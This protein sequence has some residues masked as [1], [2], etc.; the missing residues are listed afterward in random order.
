MWK[1]HAFP[2]GCSIRTSR[3][4]ECGYCSKITWTEPRFPA[5]VAERASVFS[6]KAACY[7]PLD[8]GDRA[9]FRGTWLGHGERRHRFVIHGLTSAIHGGRRRFCARHGAGIFLF[10]SQRAARSVAR[11]SVD[12]CQLAGAT[13]STSFGTPNPLPAANRRLPVRHSE[14]W[15]HTN[16][17]RTLLRRRRHGSRRWSSPHCSTGG[18]R[19]VRRHPRLCQRGRSGERRRTRG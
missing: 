4:G 3:L 12:A 7:R 17:G 8:E 5:L 2:P 18:R 19:C 15:C 11:T 14:T 1:S 10:D 9:E 6:A 13:C 16:C